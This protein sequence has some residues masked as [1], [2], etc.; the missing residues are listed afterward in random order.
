M[1]CRRQVLVMVA[2]MARRSSAARIADEKTF[3]LRHHRIQHADHFDRLAGDLGSDLFGL[4]KAAPEPASPT[5]AW[6]ISWTFLVG[7]DPCSD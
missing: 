2:R 6:S 3:C 1:S 7:H 5:H 4:N